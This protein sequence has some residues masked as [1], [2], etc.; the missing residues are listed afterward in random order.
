MIVSYSKF[1]QTFE[2]AFSSPVV[3]HEGKPYR[4]DL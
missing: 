2:F 1:M 4:M 3:M